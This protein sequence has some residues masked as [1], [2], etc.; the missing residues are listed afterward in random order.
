LTA[1]V[2]LGGAFDASVSTSRH[3]ASLNVTSSA[4]RFCSSCASLVAPMIAL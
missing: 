4:L 3:S 1:A 2:G